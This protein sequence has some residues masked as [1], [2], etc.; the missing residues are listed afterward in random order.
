ME[1]TENY[2]TVPASTKESI[3]D[4]IKKLIPVETD[5]IKIEDKFVFTIDMKYE[6]LHAAIRKIINKLLNNVS[7]DELLDFK[8][9]VAACTTAMLNVNRFNI[10]SAVA[11][12]NELA[13][14]KYKDIL[15]NI[16]EDF[17]VR[18]LLY[19]LPAFE[20]F[21]KNKY[22]YADLDLQ[23][24]TS[25]IYVKNPVLLR[26]ALLATLLNPHNFVYNY[27][28]DRI[29]YENI[30]D[31]I[32]KKLS[33][34]IIR[35][36][37]IISEPDANKI[38][39][40]MLCDI[41]TK[42]YGFKEKF[43]SSPEY[44][45]TVLLNNY[46]NIIN[47][48]WKK[49]SNDTTYGAVLSLS[50]EIK[51]YLNGWAYYF[52]EKKIDSKI[53]FDPKYIRQM[54][55][56]VEFTPFQLVILEPNTILVPSNMMHVKPQIQKAYELALTLIESELPQKERVCNESNISKANTSNFTKAI[57]DKDPIYPK[58]LDSF[59]GFFELICKPIQET[60][61]DISG[62]TKAFDSLM[63]K[64]DINYNASAPKS[65]INIKGLK[66]VLNSFDFKEK[67]EQPK[68][69]LSISESIFLKTDAFAKEHGEMSEGDAAFI[70]A[71]VYRNFYA[72]C[73]SEKVRM[74]YKKA[75]TKALYVHFVSD[76][77]MKAEHAIKLTKDLSFCISYVD[78][79]ASG[80]EDD[81]GF[82]EE[83]RELFSNELKMNFL[84]FTCGLSIE[85]LGTYFDV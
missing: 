30:N 4:I 17:E 69:K 60:I 24:E 10:W 25:S 54:E 40:T 1:K 3:N 70:A 32:A 23:T 79:F 26:Y 16:A 58:I 6:K 82:S 75:F 71:C 44:V 68:N 13:L 33:S 66:D 36:L 41:A 62:I 27:S 11:E 47:G 34:D 42:I 57:V 21:D 9:N 56:L 18:R 55:F 2:I 63:K 35:L 85:D 78:I 67:K 73:T 45:Q 77:S 49:E 83:D 64:P 7:V 20:L 5:I 39:E 48:K 53:N 28:D 51:E 12:N 38:C 31:N 61:K 52:A 14:H 43:D 22:A 8:L 76:K 37:A 50:A 29:S 80:G 15:D 84:I 74:I 46:K 65:P 81:A 59:M 19:S 72:N